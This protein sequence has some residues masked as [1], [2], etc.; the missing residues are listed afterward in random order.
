MEDYKALREKMVDCQL[1]PRGI[2][3]IRVLYAMRKVPRHLFVSDSVKAFAYEDRALPIGEN[4]TI[5]Q[6]YMVAV[7]TELLD[8]D[9][10]EKVLEI[11]TGSGYQ[12]ALLAELAAEVYTVERIAAL[13]AAASERFR[14]LNYFNIHAVVY[15]GTIGLPDKAPFDRIII[16]AAS[17]EF[18]PPLVQQLKDGGIILAP[19][20][21]R[22]SQVLVRGRKL[23]DGKLSMDY[24]TPCVFVPLIGQYGWEE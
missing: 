14:M 22:Y 2:K 15:D 9:G 16:T 7:M 13:S 21:A 5:S 20:G 10:A 1:V 24:Q 6:P 3:D 11:G 17:P 23:Q 12:A 18:P 4:Q 8:L 19:I